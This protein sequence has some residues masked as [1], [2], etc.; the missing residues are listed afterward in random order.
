MSERNATKLEIEQWIR[1]TP[2][3]EPLTEE[4]ICIS[5]FHNPPQG[6]FIPFGAQYKHT[7]PSCGYEIIIRSNIIT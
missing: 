3:F 2:G 5:P 6:L 1:N 7:C 4:L